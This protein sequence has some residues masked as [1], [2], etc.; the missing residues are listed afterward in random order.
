[1]KKI[2]MFILALCILPIQYGFSQ[3]IYQDDFEGAGNIN[4]VPLFYNNTN[5]QWEENIQVVPNPFGAGNVGKLEDTDTSYTG[6]ALCGGDVFTFDHIAIEADVYCYVGIGASTSR[7]TGVALMADTSMNLSGEISTRYVKVVADFDDN[8]GAGPRLRLYN[9][10]LNTTTF[11]YTFDV[12]FYADDIPGGIPATDSWHRFRLEARTLNPDSVEY[13]VYFDGNL[14]GGGPA[15]DYTYD[16]GS[17]IHN[18]Y[19]SGTF[20]LFAFQQGDVLPGYFDN[21]VVEQLVTGIGDQKPVVNGFDL[22]QNYPNP[23][24]P[25]TRINFVLS[26]SNLV[27]LDIFNNIGQKVRTLVNREYSAGSHEIVWNSR[28]DNGLEVP[29]GIYYYR[30]KAGDFQ[31][32]RKMLLVK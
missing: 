8:M 28:N 25:T 5:M 1:M 15:Y 6:A 22:K 26:S 14:V 7:Y 27:H 32:T 16:T 12:K 24:N 3:V 11:Q 21:V 19:T 31:Q 30:L 23:F 17:G 9:S 13:M 10:D 29:A 4:W 2:L 18:P 20:G